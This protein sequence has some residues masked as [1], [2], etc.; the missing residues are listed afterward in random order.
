MKR[1][2]IITTH[3]IQY[4]APLFRLLTLSKKITV[5]VFYTWSQAKSKVYDV[6]F[7]LERSWDIDLLDGYDYTFVNNVSNKPGSHHYK[8]IV[9]P[10]LVHEIEQ[11]EADALLVYGWNFSSHLKALRYFKGKK[12]IYSRGDSTLL[13]EP[14]GFSIKKIIRRVALTWV[15][16]HIDF[17]LYVGTANKNY[18]LAHGLK[19]NQLIYAPHAIDTNR[20]AA[21]DDE[22]NAR[23]L[24]WRS[25]LGITADEIV[26][27]FAGKLSKKK[28]PEI[29]I[30]AFKTVR[31]ESDKNMKL[32]IAGNGEL[33]TKLKDNF[34][35]DAD[36]RFV[37]FQ[38]QSIMPVLYRMADVYVLSSK[39]E[40]WGLAVNEAMA[41]SRTVVLSNKC[42][43][44]VDLVKENI[45]GY[46]FE[47]DNVHD[48]ANKISL[49]LNKEKT[50]SMGAASFSLIQDW[51]YDKIMQ[52]IENSIDKTQ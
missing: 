26:F 4:N 30:Q 32:V 20:F 11:W 47:R 33:E 15:Y 13:D 29:L 21:N 49:L 22:Q 31:D 5:K 12:T 10:T 16:R 25:E 9:N 19:L 45:N 51:N 23:A 24:K 6:D 8:G 34:E 36:I 35:K 37:G 28:N 27:L 43:C 39:S 40:T 52:A 46:V 2:A 1:L 7:K 38:N 41:C 18:Y 48:L 42:G 17:A 50:Q 44:A 14:A 3:P